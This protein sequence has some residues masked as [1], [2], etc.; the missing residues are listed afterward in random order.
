[1]RDYLRRYQ[2]T[3]I[4]LAVALFAGC[5]QYEVQSQRNP[6]PIVID[7]SDGEW[8]KGSFYYIEEPRVFLAVCNDDSFAYL[9]LRTNNI[10][11]IPQLAER[12]F[13]VWF[14]PSG[15]SD[16]ALGVHYPLGLRN[17]RFPDD[18]DNVPADLK[19][20]VEGQIQAP[21]GGEARP[22]F[23]EHDKF[24]PELIKRMMGPSDNFEILV[25]SGKNKQ[26]I[27]CD[28]S[29]TYGVGIG[30]S[31]VK[32]NYLVYELR[33]PLRSDSSVRY[34][35]TGNGAGRFGLRLVL[36]KATESRAAIKPRSFDRPSDGEGRM[37][38]GGMPGGEMP[39]GMKPGGG[40]G[41]RPMESADAE[42]DFDFKAV[43][44]LAADSHG[45]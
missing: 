34:G 27:P 37:P 39:G 26:V 45:Q 38:E 19:P 44:D 11:L 4:L 20:P 29:C 16:K 22:G 10:K 14:D 30:T 2:I 5:R 40:M 15:G 6:E 3:M 35:V 33:I 31:L 41:R 25:K 42:L 12:G 13:I 24:D 8:P 9:L 28:A 23:G 18:K 36:G 1:M 7:G 21:P 43:V 17:Q 32:D